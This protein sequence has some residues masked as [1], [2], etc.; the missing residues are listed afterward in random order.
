[1]VSQLSAAVTTFLFNTIMMDLL[2]EDG[3]AAITVIIYSQF[4]L[5]TLYIGFSIGTAPIISY[6]YGNGNTPQLKKV[7]RICLSFV[8]SISAVVFLIS[9]LEGE[10]ISEIFAKHNEN[11]FEIAKIGFT[12]FSFRFLFSGGNIF[13][14]AMFT[15]LSSGKVSAAISFLRT[16]G[17][18]TISLLFLPRFLKVMGVWL[19]I[20][21]AELITLIIAI[22]LV[23]KYRKKHNYL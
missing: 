5:T 18:I 15:A 16:F 2:G 23:F 19:A 9:F 1:M 20:P 7:I 10:N 4:L 12:V 13:I 17:L 11:V 6:N 22:C 21:I 3:V 14:S 8:I